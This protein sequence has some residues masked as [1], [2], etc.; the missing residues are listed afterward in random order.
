MDSCS[1][2]P[3]GGA[4]LPG[5]ARTAVESTLRGRSAAPPAAEGYLAQARGVFVTLRQIDGELRGCVGTLAPKCVDLV[6]ETWH[7]ACE[8]AFCDRRFPPV[9]LTELSALWFEV[10]VL[11]P[12]ELVESGKGLDPR[13]YGVVVRTPDGRRGAVLPGIAEINTVA[14]QL[15]IARKKGGIASWESATIE[16]FRVDKFLET[17]AAG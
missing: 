9:I 4:R 1:N 17:P 11:H 2:L 14:A 15:E 3:N 5:I 10:S 8:A 12:L 16:R 6:R 13:C 7:V